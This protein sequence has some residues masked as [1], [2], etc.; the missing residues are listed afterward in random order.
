RRRP[1]LHGKEGGHM[2][3]GDVEVTLTGHVALVEIQ[4]PPNNF[5]DVQLINSLGESFDELD[6]NDACRA[7]VLA[8]AGKHFCAG[9]NFG[10][11]AQQADRSARRDGDGNPLYT[12]AVRLFSVR[13]PIV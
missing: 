1:S 9:A 12:A 11:R 2:K 3:Y 8:A 5:F 10:D 4:R 7:S 6:K 13:K